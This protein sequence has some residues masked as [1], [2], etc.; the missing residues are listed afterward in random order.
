MIMDYGLRELSFG[1]QLM[2]DV[3]C[4]GNDIKKKFPI[5]NNERKVTNISQNHRMEGK[6]PFPLLFNE[7]FT[8]NKN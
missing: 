5:G 2:H 8:L 4:L 1:V 7:K 3:N 6:S